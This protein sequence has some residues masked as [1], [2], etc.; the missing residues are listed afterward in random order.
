[1]QTIRMPEL[2]AQYQVAFIEGCEWAQADLELFQQKTQRIKFR[3]QNCP[4]SFTFT[5]SVVDGGF[6]Y[7]T[8]K[9]NTSLNAGFLKYLAII[10]EKAGPITLR[11]QIEE[12]LSPKV[13]AD[14]NCE[15]V[16]LSTNVFHV[17]ANAEFM[18]KSLAK[19]FAA[20]EGDTVWTKPSPCGAFDWL[21][22]IF[23]SRDGILFGVPA[24]DPDGFANR[25]FDINSVVYENRG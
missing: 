8:A 11:Q 7:L 6:V 23:T 2:P 17:H 22:W 13:L 12:S 21:G 19:A 18:D 16:E 15:I 20:L 9:T 4:T 5:P 3:Y 10:I 25:L 14:G 24:I 1:M